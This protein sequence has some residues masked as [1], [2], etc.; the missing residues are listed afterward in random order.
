MYSLFNL[1]FHYFNQDNP[2][3]YFYSLYVHC[4]EQ[5]MFYLSCYNYDILKE[6]KFLHFK[7]IELENKRIEMIENEKIPDYLANLTISKE[8]CTHYKKI[9]QLSEWKKYSSH[10]KFNLKTFTYYVNFYFKKS[11]FVEEMIKKGFPDEIVTN[12][13]SYSDLVEP[14]KYKTIEEI[15]HINHNGVDFNFEELVNHN[16]NNYGIYD[17]QITLNLTD[18]SPSKKEIED[19]YANVLNTPDEDNY[20]LNI[21]PTFHE[22]IGLVYPVFRKNGENI[23]ILIDY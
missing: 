3:G 8:Y 9:D 14:I 21:L 16:I 1:S 17:P 23:P 7:W 20:H 18:D 6:Q 19:I 13:L 4:I 5:T 22:K 12:I 11:T 15:H 10:L 2:Y